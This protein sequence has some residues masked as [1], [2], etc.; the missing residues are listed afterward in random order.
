VSPGSANIESDSGPD[1]GKTKSA[2]TPAPIIVV[3]GVSGAG[4]TTVGD[5]LA[6]RLGCPML[7]G[8]DLHSQA[9]VRLMAE[10][11]ALTDADRQDWLSQIAARISEAIDGNRPLVVTCSALK[12]KYRDVL[13]GG[14]DG[15]TFVYLKGGRALIVERLA[16]RQNHFMP[17][18]LLDSQFEALEEPTPDEHA[19][20]CSIDRPTGDI[21]A[22]IVGALAAQRLI[23]KETRLGDDR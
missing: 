17:A 2:A 10:G 5:L 22:E 4:K 3:T 15:V 9:N 8:D 21:V 7:E 20:A 18:S 12:R 6:S 23:A 11:I 16:S 19:I 1:S 13:R 14:G